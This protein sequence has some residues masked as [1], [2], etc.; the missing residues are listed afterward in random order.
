MTNSKFQV[1][2]FMYSKKYVLD[3]LQKLSK[4]Q[5][6]VEQFGTQN[7]ATLDYISDK[8][9]EESIGNA[10][11][12]ALSLRA[13]LELFESENVEN[14]N[15]FNQKCCQNLPVSVSYSDEVLRAFIPLTFKRSTKNKT[16]LSR[17][18]AVAIKKYCEENQINLY[19][20]MQAP[21]HELVKRKSFVF[22]KNYI[23]DADKGDFFA[24]GNLLFSSL[25]LSDSARNMGFTS[26]YQKCEPGEEGMEIVIFPQS[27]LPLMIDE[28]M[29]KP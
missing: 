7:V 29:V 19:Q 6:E 25:G 18:V 2:S 12:L 11:K 26:V 16:D 14:S 9:I 8:I 28:M 1:Q 15:D 4:F 13:N 23:N 24:I 3:K 17:I 10:E 27:K 5:H 20:I 21:V 22:N